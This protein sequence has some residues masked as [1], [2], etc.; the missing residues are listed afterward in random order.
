MYRSIKKYQ[1]TDADKDQAFY[2]AVK[3]RE[4][5]VGNRASNAE[6]KKVLLRVLGMWENKNTKSAFIYGAQIAGLIDEKEADLLRKDE[7]II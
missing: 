2:Y 4:P 5:L 3:R 6:R 1:L 7:K